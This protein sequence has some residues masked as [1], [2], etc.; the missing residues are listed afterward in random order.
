M[1][2]EFN[3]DGVRE[4]V[5]YFPTYGGCGKELQAAKAEIALLQAEARGRV[6]QNET[7]KHEAEQWELRYYRLLRQRNDADSAK[8]SHD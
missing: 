3:Q 1:A 5:Y 2:N 8:V 4:V 6:K 7:L